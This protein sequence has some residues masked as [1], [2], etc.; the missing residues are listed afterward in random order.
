[1]RPMT[2]LGSSLDSAEYLLLFRRNCLHP[3]W[4]PRHETILPVVVADSPSATNGLATRPSRCPSAPSG[5][6]WTP[7]E[8]GALARGIQAGPAVANPRLLPRRPPHGW[9]LAEL[10]RVRPANTA[11][12]RRQS[13]VLGGRFGARSRSGT[14]RGFCFP[15]PRRH[16]RMLP[17]AS[18]PRQSPAPT[19]P[20]CSDRRSPRAPEP[21]PDHDALL[22]LQ[23]S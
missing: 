10:Q 20:A 23:V 3:G 1:M 18:P 6:A 8:Q 17:D 22:R 19:H 5:E 14:V 2:L 21:P 13:S 12:F 15:P 11:R 16:G 7:L 4:R 9:K